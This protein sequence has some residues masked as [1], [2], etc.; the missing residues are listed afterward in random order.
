MHAYKISQP[1]YELEYFLFGTGP[2]VM[3]AFHGFN[4]SAHDFVSLERIAGDKY[5]IVSVNIF[6]HGNSMVEEHLVE[7]GFS[8]NEL[9]ALFG[10]LFNIKPSRK[11]TLMGYSLGGRI[12]LKMLELFPERIEKI[13]LLAPDGL[14]I[15]PFYTFFTRTIVGKNI[16]KNAVNNPASFHNIARFLKRTRIISEKR[17]Q[18]AFTNFENKSKREKVYRTWMLFKNVVTGQET[19]KAR[20]REH[21]IH[22]FLF[23]GRYDKIIPPSIGENFKK[24]VEKLVNLYILDEGHRLIRHEILEKVINLTEKEEICSKQS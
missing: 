15:N 11:Y 8:N 14:K 12:V 16:L 1:S 9:K 4:N 6:F 5:T 18:F 21:K 23:F 13:I 22:L 2:K 20:L 19:I 17:Y 10:D 3:L 24:G 7:R